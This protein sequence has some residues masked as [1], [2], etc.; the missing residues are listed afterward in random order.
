MRKRASTQEPIS[1]PTSLAGDDQAESR[2]MFLY[3]QSRE[4]RIKANLERMQKLGIFDLSQKLRSSSVP[5]KRTPNRKPS[6]KC[7][8]APPSG[9][10]R[11]S[12]RWVLC[13]GAGPCGEAFWVL[14]FGLCLMVC[15]G[16]LREKCGSVMEVVGFD[17]RCWCVLF[18]KNVSFAVSKFWFLLW[19]GDFL[20]C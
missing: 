5:P 2:K 18:G 13:D 16:L 8:P 7:A 12:S 3:E 14:G 6:E 19:F 20:F 9:P 17:Q 1:T 15:L 11:R 4:E 10:V